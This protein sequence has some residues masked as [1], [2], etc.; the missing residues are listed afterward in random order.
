MAFFAGKTYTISIAGTAK[1]LDKVEVD[2]NGEKV[3]VTNFSSAGW[4]ELLAGGGIKSVKI[5]ASGPYNGVASGA[6]TG[7]HV[8]DTVAI[9]CTYSA[10]PALT[11]SCQLLDVKLPIDVR[12]AGQI[13]YE[14]ESTA[15]PT[16]LY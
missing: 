8:T 2:I 7:D 9:I 16:L 14:L 5:T 3:D 1:P 12:G 10:G 15:A 11:I 13:S 4:Q 6:T